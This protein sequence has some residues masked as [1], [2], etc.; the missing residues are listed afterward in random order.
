MIKGFPGEGGEKECSCQSNNFLPLVFKPHDTLK[1][2]RELL[3]ILH[4][5]LTPC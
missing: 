2:L 4:I 5:D 1:L 3:K